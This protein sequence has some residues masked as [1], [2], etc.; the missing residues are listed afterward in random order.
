[1]EVCFIVVSWRGFDVDIYNFRNMCFSMMSEQDLFNLSL[2]P[3][4]EHNSVPAYLVLSR[5]RGS[6]AA[7]RISHPWSGIQLAGGHGGLLTWQSSLAES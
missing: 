6:R 1:M 7:F 2:G 5:A 4:P 3:K